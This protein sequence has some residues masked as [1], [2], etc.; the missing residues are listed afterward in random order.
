MKKT[1]RNLNTRTRLQKTIKILLAMV[2]FLAIGKMILIRPLPSISSII[3]TE[4]ET[5]VKA[6]D[7]VLQLTLEAREKILKEVRLNEI[8]IPQSEAE[9]IRRLSLIR[10]G[11]KIKFIIEQSEAQKRDNAASIRVKYISQS[12]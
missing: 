1:R 6:G 7:S 11:D 12:Q 4:S 8:I 10:P 9:Y 5:E 3:I 2:A